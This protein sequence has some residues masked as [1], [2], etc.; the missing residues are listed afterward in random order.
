[1][2]GCRREIHT[3]YIVVHVSLLYFNFLGL[4][5]NFT[6]NFH[7]IAIFTTQVSFL[8]ILSSIFFLIFLHLQPL[9][10]DG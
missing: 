2:I 10:L 8:Q 1:M 6:I 4:I 7:Y 9:M 5:A 3:K